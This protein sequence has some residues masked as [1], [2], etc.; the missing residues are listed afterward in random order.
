[1]SEAEV[2]RTQTGVRIATPLLKVLRGLA[3]YK[4]MSL[5]DLIEGIVLHAFD[6]KT[7]FTKETLRVIAQL[8]DVYGL[9]LTSA[10]AHAIKEKK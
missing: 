7:P 8:R 4:D 9:E 6:N 10:D 1:M 2:E 3:D 5:G